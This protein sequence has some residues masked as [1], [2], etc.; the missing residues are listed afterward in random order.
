MRK[1]VVSII[2]SLDGY[3][4]GPGADIMALPMDD[5]FNVHNLRRM[6]EAD[7]LLYGANTYRGM[8]GFWPAAAI[9][10]AGSLGGQASPEQIEVIREIGILSNETHKVTVSDTMTKD[11]LAPWTDTT[12]IV[13][14]ADA[15]E[16]V[17]KLKEQPGRDILMFGSRI[18]WTDLLTAGLV[19]EFHV[20]VGATTLAGGTPA[21]TTPIP[22]LRLLDTHR[23]EGSDNVVL[24]YE[25]Q[26]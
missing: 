5:F 2:T 11:D 20:M 7:T 3:F 12:T 10:P 6:H 4:E 22:N 1:L 9:D 25:V 24:H 17:T 21:F 26:R 13:R 19:D 23:Y 14:R 18:L 8:Q 16:F 15:R